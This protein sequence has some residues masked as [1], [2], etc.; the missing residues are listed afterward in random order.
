MPAFLH[1][2]LA[3]L[4]GLP[5]GVLQCG[6]AEAGQWMLQL[7]LQNTDGNGN[8]RTLFLDSSHINASRGLTVAGATG[9]TV[10]HYNLE[11]SFGDL[12]DWNKVLLEESRLSPQGTLLLDELDDQSVTIFYRLRQVFPEPAPA[13]FV[14]IPPGTYLRGDQGNDDGP[15]IMEARPVHSASTT[16][17]FISSNLVTYGDWQVVYNWAL[18]SGYTFDNAGQRGSNS[19]GRVFSSNTSDNDHP[20]V[21]VNWFDVIKWC[22]AKSEMEGLQPVYFTNDARTQ[23]YRMG[24]HALSN[25][26]VSPTANGYRLPTEVQWEKAARGGLSAQR[27]PWGNEPINPLRA[28]YATATDE[29]RTTRVGSYPANG[30]GLFDVSGN[31]FEWCWDWYDA[32]WYSH[33]GSREVDTSGPSPVGLSLRVLRSG[34]WDSPSN[35]VRVAFRRGADPTLRNSNRGFRLVRIFLCA[36]CALSQAASLNSLT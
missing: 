18:A 6:M 12:S 31:V 26:Q 21:R 1:T 32:N 8:S 34:G 15:P 19:Q 10:E 5:L 36:N 27:W 14:Y 28:N 29:N 22:N 35:D 20:V 2:K 23:V 9:N 13:G 11:R 24:Q 30:Y 16:S 25:L 7:E 33:S 17:F 3:F 4:L